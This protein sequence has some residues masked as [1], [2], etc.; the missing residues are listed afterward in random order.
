MITRRHIVLGWCCGHAALTGQDTRRELSPR[1]LF[2]EKEGE[3]AAHSER[4]HRL[5]LRYNLIKLAD[6]GK[7][8]VVSPDT[9]FHEG[10][11]VAIDVAPNCQGY[12]YVLQL[13]STG[14]LTT[15][16]P[17]AQADIPEQP[18]TVAAFREV[19]V[20]NGAWFEFD[21]NPGVERL[22]IVVSQRPEDVKRLGEAIRNRAQPG[23]AVPAGDETTAELRRRDIVV[24]KIAAAAGPVERPNSVY[25]VNAVYRP[26]DQ[27]TVEVDLRHGK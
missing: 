3:P 26:N 24:E 27:L 18:K 10:D 19:R 23:P 2:Y 12:L 13:G 16:L 5:A 8:V 17:S 1:D 20:P 6:G 15:L 4:P 25:V 9:V 22:F 7:P 21:N 11:S 14:E